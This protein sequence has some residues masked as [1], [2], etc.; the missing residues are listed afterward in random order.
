M[1][2]EKFAGKTGDTFIAGPQEL[3]LITRTTQT[4]AAVKRMARLLRVATESAQDSYDA[5]TSTDPEPCV[6]FEIHRRVPT[7]ARLA[8][9]SRTTRARLTHDR[10][11]FYRV[12]L[13]NFLKKQGLNPR[14]V[15][16]PN[17]K[18]ESESDKTQKGLHPPQA[19][20]EP[21]VAT[22]GKREIPEG[23]FWIAGHLRNRILAAFPD[24]RIPDATERGLT[25]W[26]RVVDRMLRI[27]GREASKVV[28][29]IDWALGA[30]LKRE[31]SF[32]V[33]SAGALRSKYD[34]MSI[35]AKRDAEEK[36]SGRAGAGA[37]GDT[38][39]NAAAR[40]RSRIR[41]PE[42]G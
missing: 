38:V 4:A 9:D 8:H 25:P 12:G 2:I 39:A 42:P 40:V 18:S 41:Q 35:A 34:S 36:A 11:N 22:R 17:P 29:A 27:D 23:C 26:A 3:Q 21:A 28:S 33:L 37:T 6:V 7:R 1:S 13:R 31:A 10:V 14:T 24:A 32:V 20:G 15:T 30:N 16:P 19:E 5:G